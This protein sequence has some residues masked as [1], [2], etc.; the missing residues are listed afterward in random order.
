MRLRLCRINLVYFGLGSGRV[1]SVFCYKPVGLGWL[2]SARDTEATIGFGSDSVSFSN[3]S[4]RIG[5][6]D[7]TRC[8]TL[9]YTPYVIS[10]C[11]GSYNKKSLS[12]TLTFW[13]L[14]R[15]GNQ[16]D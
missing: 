13:T 1:G 14:G 3:G 5:E 7:P 6:S 8:T 2:G 11:S 12:S 9:F 10:F 4:G 15:H 16:E